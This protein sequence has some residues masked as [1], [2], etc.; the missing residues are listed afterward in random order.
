VVVSAIE[1]CLF[2]TISNVVLLPDVFIGL[3]V[4]RAL[5]IIGLLLVFSSSIFVM[6]TDVRAVNAFAVAKQSGNSTD[7]SSTVDNDYI[8]C[9]HSSYH[10]VRLILINYLEAR[11]Y[12]ISPLASFGR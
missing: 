3:N 1:A 2:I 12:L 9:A 10:N 11:L 5:S 6:V 8:Q 4:V 7:T